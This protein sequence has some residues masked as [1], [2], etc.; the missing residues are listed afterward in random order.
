LV[1][2]LTRRKVIAA[3]AILVL[4]GNYLF[5]LYS[6]TP[7]VFALLDLFLVGI[8]VLLY[9]WQETHDVR[10]FWGACVVFGLSLTHHQMILFAVPAF[11]Y[12]VWHDRHLFP[13]KM[14]H[15]IWFQSVFWI[16]IGLVPFVWA[17]IAASHPTI[18]D[19]DK[20]NTLANFIHLVTRSDY[21]TFVSNNVFGELF[22]DRL[23]A[24]LA[25]VRFVFIDFRL[26]GVV[27]IG[28]GSFNVWRR[29]RS[30]F[31]F[32]TIAWVCL[33]P[34]FFFYASFPL[35]SRFTLGTYERF[36]L[37]SYIIVT[38]VL[39]VGVFEFTQ[40]IA[41]YIAPR[42]S[43]LFSPVV[44]IGCTALLFLYPLF[45]IGTNVWRFWGLSGD[46]TADNL[47]LDILSSLPKDSILILDADTKLF[48]T[49]Y[50][51]YALGVRRDVVVLHAGRLQ[52]DDYLKEIQQLFPDI[53]MPK[54]ADMKVY[55]NLIQ[56]N[57]NHPIFATS[58]LEI[59]SNYYWIPFGLVY[60][61]LTKDEL[62]T[63]N[64]MK[65]T[66]LTLWSRFHDPTTGIL[67]RYNHFML[68]DIKNV[69]AGMRKEFG[70]V[71]L[72]AGEFDE[73]RMQFQKSIAYN[74][75]VI[76]GDTF[77][78][79]GASDMYLKRCNEALQSFALARTRALGNPDTTILLY[80]GMTYR[81]CLGDAAKGQKFLDEYATA[82]KNGQTPL[83]KL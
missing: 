46:R 28:L 53:R 25:Y 8:T 3:F 54:T 23:I 55:Q 80:E 49:Q 52:F 2:R 78:L 13:K 11:C 36:L 1:E 71:L 39:S 82:V 67:S 61:A 17:P 57:R 58:E 68:S 75:D 62:P 44:I 33:G 7:E 66:N 32:L 37:P 50:V 45:M 22:I 76:N 43:R 27:L 29:K 64:D 51:R 5:F 41:R 14:R 79:L 42:F 19:W 21:G 15:Y 73:A 60:E 31:W 4:I 47:G 12:W 40:L 48:T 35:T 56:L 26:L 30:L 83:E 74:G 10:F 38:I 6:V 69:Y 70:T 77:I 16:M 81:D 63:V 72:K 18:I 9:R 20:P 34:L 65:E 24:L 59:G